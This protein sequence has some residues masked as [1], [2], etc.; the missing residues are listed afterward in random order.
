[1]GLNRHHR[2]PSMKTK[3]KEQRKIHIKAEWKG[4]ALLQH[5]RMWMQARAVSR[6]NS[7]LDT[8]K[9]YAQYL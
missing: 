9:A 3:G 7:T 5:G 8:F 1:M 6:R 2:A 4:A